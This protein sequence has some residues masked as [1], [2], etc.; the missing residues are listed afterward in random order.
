MTWSL[1]IYPTT[2]RFTTDSSRIKKCISFHDKYIPLDKIL[3]KGI[4]GGKNVIFP[5]IW[6]IEDN[7]FY[8]EYFK[9]NLIWILI[10]FWNYPILSIY[11]SIYLFMSISVYSYMS[12]YWTT[13]LS[14]SDHIYLRYITLKNIIRISNGV[15]LY[16]YLYIQ[17]WVLTKE[18]SS[19]VFWTFGRTR[20]EIE[21][22][23]PASLANTLTILPMGQ[24]WV[25]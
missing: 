5:K 20:P 3:K 13:D 10:Y 11:L 2:F 23:S 18:V 1:L 12:I 6:K 7:S 22:Q 19:T 4:F 25:I 15:K 14:Q 17:Y 9:L 8:Q 24:F 21:P 16:I